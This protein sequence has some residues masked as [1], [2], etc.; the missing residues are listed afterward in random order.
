LE[1]E[2]NPPEDFMDNINVI[3]V[4]FNTQ[5]IKITDTTGEIDDPIDRS[6]AVF[7]ML[8]FINADDKGGEAIKALE[9]GL[10]KTSGGVEV[11]PVTIAPIKIKIGRA[12]KEKA[13]FQSRLFCD[14]DLR[15]GKAFSIVD[16]SIAQPAYHPAIFVA[17]DDGSIRYRC[18]ID[19]PD[20]NWEQIRL[21]ISKLI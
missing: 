13:G 12:F 16:S 1:D 7:T 4:G 21:T 9:S 17:G 20:V 11:I 5:S 15:L 14:N 8:C 18:A 10:P 3:R 2:L 6:G 19:S